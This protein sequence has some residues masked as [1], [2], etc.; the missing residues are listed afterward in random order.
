MIMNNKY[1]KGDYV[2]YTSSNGITDVVRIEDVNDKTVTLLLI[3]DQKNIKTYSPNIKLIKTKENHLIMLG[4]EKVINKQNQFKYILGNIIIS[5]LTYWDKNV[6]FASGLCLGDF[7]NIPTVQ[8]FENGN[9]KSIDFYS[10][11]PNIENN[12][13]DL[14]RILDTNKIHYNKEEIIF[15]DK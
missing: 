4:F 1:L 11:F 10:N 2:L 9:F 6:H 5:G 12:I 3:K 8:Y 15:N 13:N 7:E 14:F